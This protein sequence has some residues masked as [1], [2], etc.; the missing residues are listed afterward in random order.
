MKILILILTDSR[1]K[2]LFFLKGISKSSRKE[3]SPRQAMQWIWVFYHMPL[4]VLQCYIHIYLVCKCSLKTRQDN[5]KSVDFLA[6]I[7][8]FCL[9][10]L[11]SLKRAKTYPRWLSSGQQTSFKS[12]KV[13]RGKNVSR[14]THFG[15]QMSYLQS[16]FDFFLK[17]DFFWKFWKEVKCVQVD[18]FWSPIE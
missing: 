13:W 9:I 15:R 2:W 11:N 1:L 4:S 7:K 10:D 3:A 17:I 16:D 6:Q 12:E 5:N 18:A 8:V 14:W